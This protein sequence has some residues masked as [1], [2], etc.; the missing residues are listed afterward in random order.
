MKVFASR[1]LPIITVFMEKIV[2]VGVR[3]KVFLGSEVEELA[4]GELKNLTS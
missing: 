2:D 3:V 4:S 1:D